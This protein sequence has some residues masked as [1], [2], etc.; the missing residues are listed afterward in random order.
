MMAGLAL[1]AVAIGMVVAYRAQRGPVLGTVAL[2]QGSPMLVVD[3]RTAWEQMGRVIVLG[4]PPFGSLLFRGY[5]SVL[6]TH[7][8]QLVHTTTP[9]TVGGAGWLEAPP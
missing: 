6:D 8:G 3:A 9:I 4:E 5:V 7:S 1:L 2:D